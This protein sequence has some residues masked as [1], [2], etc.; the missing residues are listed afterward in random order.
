MVHVWGVVRLVM[1]RA[2]QHWIRPDAD[3]VPERLVRR[4]RSTGRVIA[5]DGLVD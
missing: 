1:V 3:D 4:R 5:G 2:A